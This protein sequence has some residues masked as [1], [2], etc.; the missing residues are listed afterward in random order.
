MERKIVYT[1]SA[2]KGL[3]KMP[4]THKVKMI[5]TL[6]AI[7]SDETKGLDV[8]KMKGQEDTY[9]LRVGKYRAIYTMDM[10]IMTIEKIGPRGSIY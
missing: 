8:K 7:A 9:C 5:T 1:K 3:K 2:E 6:K 10:V 4:K